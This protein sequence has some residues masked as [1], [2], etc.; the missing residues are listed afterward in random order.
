MLPA[1]YVDG[2]A[3][4]NKVEYHLCG[5]GLGIGIDQTWGCHSMISGK[6][7]DMRPVQLRMHSPLDNA[8][9]QGYLLQTSQCP[10]GF[11]LIVDLV[12]QLLPQIHLCTCL[13]ELVLFDS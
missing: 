3:S 8:C 4:G 10:L 6:H 13:H 11:G 7:N 12:L 9:L 5:D 2:R 1:E